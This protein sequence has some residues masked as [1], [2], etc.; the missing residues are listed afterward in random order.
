MTSPV[1]HKTLTFERDFKSPAPRLFQA[2]RD[3]IARSHWGPPGEDE[4]I[5]YLESDF[6]VGGIDK[7]RCGERTNPTFNVETR[8]LD[9]VPD[10]RI[11]TSEVVMQGENRL[12]ASLV[13]VEIFG[14]AEGT[15]LKVVVQVTSLIGL[16]MIE[17]F[18]FGWS[19][20]LDG[21]VKYVY[22][23]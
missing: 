13:T 23:I 5:E 8:Y 9:I 17:G 19:A 15:K 16:D 7:S 22:R 1:M 11:V 21:L 3:P 4:V 6:S 20:S 2:F 14:G 18:E 10:S 12:A